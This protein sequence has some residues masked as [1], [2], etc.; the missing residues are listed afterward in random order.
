MIRGIMRMLG[1]TRTP[2]VTTLKPPRMHDVSDGAAAVAATVRVGGRDYIVVADVVTEDDSQS[3]CPWCLAPLLPEDDIV[4]CPN[5]HCRSAGHREHVE[6]F[7]CG[8][9]CGIVG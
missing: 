8:G 9:V 7:G 2:R 5:A 6:S 1:F 4:V 3:V